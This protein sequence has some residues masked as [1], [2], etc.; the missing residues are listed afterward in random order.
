MDIFLETVSVPALLDEVRTLATPLAANNQNAL[1][2]KI[3]PGV[4]LFRTDLTKLK[5]SLLNL[6]S[7]ACKFTKNGRVELDVAR[8]QGAK[9][10]E[11]H[12]TVTDS[13]IG[14]SEEQIGKL[15]QPFVQA[16]SST[17]RQFGGTGLGLAITRQLCR[18]L[19]GDIM[20]SSQSGQGSTFKII[21][22][23]QLPEAAEIRADAEREE[24]QGLTGGVA[25]LVVDDDPQVHDLLGAMLTR[26]GYRVLHANNGREA[27]VRAR[28]ELPAA[29]LLDIMMPQIDGWTVLTELK[30]DAGLA[31]IPVVIVSMLDERPLGLSL[32]AA[33]FITKPVD[34]S[35][36]IATLAQH[37]GHAEGTALIVEDQEADRATL[38]H[39]LRSIGMTVAECT[40]GREALAWLEQHTPPTVMIL[41]IMMPEL[42][43]FAVLEAVRR[44]DRLNKLPV[45]VLTAK[46]LTAA[47]LEY[48]HGRGGI[49]IPKSPEARE[50]LMAA[51]RKAA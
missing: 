40:N 12:F 45:L 43:G 25:V 46:D 8:H 33:E 35:K 30:E 21:L 7:N 17:T 19:G 48:L 34:R 23:L 37:I 36:L 44:D 13:G 29:I 9:G 3:E 20:V 26:E 11:L 5:Q 1:S 14:M 32:G 6:I 31:S 41:D 51:L 47:E 16:D 24:A 4:D 39:M 49:V 22:P 10:E 2:V 42:D 18:M 27:I 50:K 15:F 38:S 28:K